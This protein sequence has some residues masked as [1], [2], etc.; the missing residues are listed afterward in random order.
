M[1][2]WKG[3]C[4][5]FLPYGIIIRWVFCSCEAIWEFL[6]PKW[7]SSFFEGILTNLLIQVLLQRWFWWRLFRSF[8]FQI[9][10]ISD[11][12]LMTFFSCRWLLLFHWLWWWTRSYFFVWYSFRIWS[13]WTLPMIFVVID[14]LCHFIKL[15][16]KIHFIKIED[17]SLFI[18]KVRLW[19]LIWLYT[20]WTS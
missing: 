12:I 18:R 3:I 14:W 7:E 9:L 17:D 8:S 2:L 15:S 11:T 13:F 1:S 20:V 6:S 5:W 10:Y 4:V 16:S 19:F